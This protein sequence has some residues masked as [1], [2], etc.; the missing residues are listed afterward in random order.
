MQ[1]PSHNSESGERS[2]CTSTYAG[3]A[4][5]CKTR[6]HLLN[7][8]P[9]RRPVGSKPLLGQ[10]H[11]GSVPG[12]PRLSSASCMCR[13]LCVCARERVHTRTRSHTLFTPPPQHETSPGPRALPSTWGGVGLRGRRRQGRAPLGRHRHLPLSVFGQRCLHSLRVNICTEGTTA[14]HTLQDPL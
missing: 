14:K 12:E 2:H 7:S 10:G 4:L 13:C 3:S 11:A 9:H 1:E 6:M 8:N 5:Y